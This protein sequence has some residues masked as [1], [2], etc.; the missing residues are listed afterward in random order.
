MQP[1]TPA[2]FSEALTT[3]PLSSLYAKISE[4]QNSIAHLERSN[5]EIRQFIDESADQD[6]ELEDA[7]NENGTV[8]NNMTE[9]IGLVEAELERRGQRLTQAE[10]IS[11]TTQ[12]AAVAAGQSQSQ[13]QPEPRIQDAAVGEPGV[14]P[15]GNTSI[16]NQNGD[17]DGENRNGE[18]EDAV[19]L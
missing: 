15:N 14:T 4:L 18:D 3:L 5:V 11:N 10:D 13:S 1:I 7:I 12:P 8:I 6:P 16:A 17:G 19:Y 9:R 2:V